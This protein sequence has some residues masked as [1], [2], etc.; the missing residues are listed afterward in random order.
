MGFYDLSVCDMREYPGGGNKL[1]ES[2]NIRQEMD[3]IS[4]V[5]QTNTAT[6]QQT[7]AA[8]QELSTQARSLSDLIQKFTI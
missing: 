7:A 3:N 5:V 1:S 4:D 8:T 6:A 2:V